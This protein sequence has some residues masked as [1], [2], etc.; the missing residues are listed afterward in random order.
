MVVV[1][2]SLPLHVALAENAADSLMRFKTALTNTDRSLANWN[3][4]TNPCIGKWAGVLCYNGYVWALQ[5]DNM[6]L[7]GQI[8]VDSL[9]E[10][11]YLRTLSF[12]NNNFQGS[13]PNWRK[14][15]ILMSLYLSD[16]HFS[17]QIA[18]DAFEGMES[19]KKVYLSDNSFTGPI[20]GSLASPRMVE[21]GLDNNHFSG[22]IPAIHS[23]NLQVFNVSNNDLQGPVPP[24][25]LKLDPSSFTGNKALCGGPNGPSC[26]LPKP[27]P[28][29]EPILHHR[30]SPPPGLRKKSSVSP[31]IIAI[32][33]LSIML[34]LL[35]LLLLLLLCRWILF[36]DD[37]DGDD[38]VKPQQKDMMSPLPVGALSISIDGR[39][40]QQRQRQQQAS[41]LSFVKEDRQKF[42]LQD[43]M[44][45]SAEVL[46][47]GSFGSSYKAVLVDG[48]AVVVKRFK[49]MNNITKEDFHEHMKRLGRLK[50]PNLLPLVAYLYRREEKLVVLDFVQNNSLAKHLH[51]DGKRPKEWPKP[52][53]WESRLKAIKGVARGLAYLHAE[54]PSLNAPHGHLKSSNVM[55][56][57]NY[58]ALL[59]DYTLS[60]IVNPS[61]ISQ[62]LVVYRC[63]E[64]AQ[65][66]R[67]GRKSDVWCLGIL[68]LETLTGKPVDKYMGADLLKWVKG[69]VEEAEG[70][71]A[72][73][74]DKSMETSKRSQLEINML[75]QIGIACCQE[76][77]DKRLGLEE[78]VT[79]IEQL[80]E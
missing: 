22:A 70:R 7:Q 55:L 8:D 36:E 56:D 5:L 3:P 15:G 42:D 62:A 4:S 31:A 43:L 61:Q 75:L 60:P 80:Q 51:D 77:L 35:L 65:T 52:L 28:D 18:N 59:M 69:I 34:I 66:G 79:R 30:P 6:G 29:L 78:A 72:M 50:H 25:L 9:A 74:F 16:N 20:P 10:L 26:N 44:R 11:S 39:G 49:Q 17:G 14:L 1:A 68:I 76:D 37:D 33:I 38:V 46:G 64:Y 24:S 12:I 73:V 23:Q 54:L 71:G 53:S 58:N 13:M 67:I 40:E 27:P 45:A 48:D 19:L 41:K 32:I 21:V 57:R 2:F 47:S 63:P